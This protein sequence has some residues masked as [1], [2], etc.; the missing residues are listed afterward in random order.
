MNKEGVDNF[1]FEIIEQVED[2]HLNER[3]IYWV[4]KL[5]A[6]S[7]N[8]YNLTKGGEGT[9]GYS[10]PQSVE[11]REKRSLSNKKYYA[12]H[13]EAKKAIGERTKKLWEDEEYRR[14]VTEGNKKFYQEHPDMFKGENNPMYGKKHTE[15]AL[16]KIR[17]N[18]ATR[19]LK[20]AQLDKNTLE[21]IKIHDGVKDA[22]KEL[23]VSHGWISKAA[24]Q[25]K[26][27]YGFKWKFI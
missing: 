19:K 20:I 4:E 17:A 6:L 25:D 24:K 10:R 22:E 16:E 27:A 13:P 2:E 9:V 7:P 26:I 23:G 3:E 1:N 8:G 18:A 14:K 15:E 12:E 5:G 11:E 21:I